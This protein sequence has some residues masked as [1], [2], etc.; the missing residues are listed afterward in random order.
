MNQ[1]IRSLINSYHRNQTQRS[2]SALNLPSLPDLALILLHRHEN[3]I[4]LAI[5]ALRTKLP[6]QN[7]TNRNSQPKKKI[8]NPRHRSIDRSIER[9]RKEATI[10]QR[11]STREEIERS[12]ERER[13]YARGGEGDR[14]EEAPPWSDL[15]QKKMGKGKRRVSGVG[16]YS[17]VQRG[18]HVVWP[19]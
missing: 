19:N 13:A 5:K 10:E 18:D 6:V 2:T 15:L 1:A 17:G 14:D 8:H 11:S 16:L 3:T 12:R 9:T 4:R 7:L